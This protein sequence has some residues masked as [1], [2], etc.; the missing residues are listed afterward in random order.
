MFRHWHK[1]EVTLYWILRA[2]ASSI[3]RHHIPQVRVWAMVFSIRRVPV[4]TMARRLP[5]RA[6]TKSS[7]ERKAEKQRIRKTPLIRFSVRRPLWNPWTRDEP[8]KMPIKTNVVRNVCNQFDFLF[9]NSRIYKFPRDR[10]I[11]SNFFFLHLATNP[12]VGVRM[13]ENQLQILDDLPSSAVE[14]QVK[15]KVRIDGI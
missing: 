1:M 7:V 11:L 4:I 2:T 12:K 5:H 10:K 3:C 13:D 6:V 15:D 14:M 9:L 8:R